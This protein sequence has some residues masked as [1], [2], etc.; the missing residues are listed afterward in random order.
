LAEGVLQMLTEQARDI[1]RA[2]AGGKRHDDLD[3]P[4]RVVVVGRNGVR[5]RNSQ[6]HERGEKAQSCLHRIIPP[7]QPLLSIY[8]DI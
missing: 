8:T 6:Q 5:H 7:C 2:G 1:V 3:L 4:R